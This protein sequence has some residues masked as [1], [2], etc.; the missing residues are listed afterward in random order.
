MRLAVA[1]ALR[2]SSQHGP[3]P[4]LSIF[5]QLLTEDYYVANKLMKGF[6]G[7]ANVD[8]NSRL[9]SAS[10]V[11]GRRRCPARHRVGQL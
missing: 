2:L 7:S 4:L 10:S 3:D 6:I 5:G 11:A 9:G 1:K 8:T